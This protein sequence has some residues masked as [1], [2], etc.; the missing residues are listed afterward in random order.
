MPKANKSNFNLYNPSLRKYAVENRNASTKAE[1]C[2]WKYVLRAR[3]MKGY[4]FL[5]QRPVLNYIADFMCKE[6]KLII[7]VD[8][9]THS[10]EQTTEKDNFRQKALE[11]AG[12]KLLRYT[13]EEVLTALNRVQESIKDY[14]IGLGRK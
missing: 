12:F 9:L 5:R 7:E 1:A 8:G 4:S 14:I 3:K 6:L 13:D 10:Y 11:K 2:L